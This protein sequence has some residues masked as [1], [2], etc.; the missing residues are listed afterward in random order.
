M[1]DTACY[2]RSITQ[3]CLPS[4]LPRSI[5]LMLSI[6]LSNIGRANDKEIEYFY[7]RLTGLYLTHTDMGTYHFP[8][9]IA[10]HLLPFPAWPSKALMACNTYFA[11]ILYI[12]HYN[13]DYILLLSKYFMNLFWNLFSCLDLKPVESGEVAHIL[14]VSLTNLY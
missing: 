5:R 7:R 12:V 4:Y 3:F 1:T 6:I 14:L 9:T 2:S 11:L 10:S 8:I 13:K